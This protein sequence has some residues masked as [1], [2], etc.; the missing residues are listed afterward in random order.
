[1]AWAQRSAAR[2]L[3]FVRISSLSL[4]S[5]FIHS[6]ISLID[7][8]DDLHVCRPIRRPIE[9]FV[10]GSIDQIRR[11]QVHISHG[12][13]MVTGCDA[14]RRCEGR[15]GGDVV[16]GGGRSQ[17]NGR[18]AKRSNERQTYELRVDAMRGAVAVDGGREEWA[19]GFDSISSDPSICRP[20][21]PVDSP[22][23]AHLNQ[24]RS[25]TLLPLTHSPTNSSDRP[26]IRVADLRPNRKRN[27]FEI[28]LSTWVSHEE[29]LAHN[30]I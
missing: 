27:P 18:M 2:R 11:R 4:S 13:R 19:I 6:R 9:Q 20:I 3:L 29:T 26:A 30:P 5:S 16:V 15:S 7:E 1:M 22:T 21:P 12:G 28:S 23:G 10:R 17:L 8:V 14:V 25:P 24:Q